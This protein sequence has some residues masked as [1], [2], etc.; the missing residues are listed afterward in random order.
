MGLHP[1]LSNQ[2]QPRTAGNKA[3]ET[4][5]VS[6]SVA[7]AA[8][9]FTAAQHQF[10]YEN[11]AF[12]SQ[13]GLFAA[14]EDWPLEFPTCGGGRQSPIDLSGV[15]P[16]DLGPFRFRDYHRAPDEVTVSNNGQTS[17]VTFSTRK[18]PR[19]SGGGLPG[20]YVLDQL[21]FHW[22]SNPYRGSEHT[23]FGFRFPM[24]M[25]MVH[26]NSKFENFTEAL[27]SE[28]PTA[29]AVFGFFLEVSK[30]WIPI[31]DNLVRALSHVK[32]PDTEHPVNPPTPP[33]RWLP[34]GPSRFYRYYGSL[35]TP[36][37]DQVVVWT[38]FETPIPI[39]LRQWEQWNRLR[40]MA[41][42]KLT[43]NI[44]PLQARNGRK[45]LYDD[46]FHCFRDNKAK[47]KRKWRKKIVPIA[48]DSWPTWGP[49]QPTFP[50]DFESPT[51]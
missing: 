17:M 9:S 33:S 5:K 41:G 42:T 46:C 35:T 50:W 39:G 3:T 45:I 34:T 30:D 43:N 49:V 26:F 40:T 27:A 29:V 32:E 51:A 18:T 21:H 1:A 19:V 8:F 15:V 24:E 10:S 16:A 20:L 47:R 14:A 7:L 37:C 22:G 23:L 6:V 28:E 2:I 44:R 36:A 13:L 38:L 11:N 31:W 25:H 12:T 48:G 4:E